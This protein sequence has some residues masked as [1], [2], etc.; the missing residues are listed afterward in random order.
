MSAVTEVSPYE[1][2]ATD[3]DSR[4]VEYVAETRAAVARSRTYRI[5]GWHH[6]AALALNTAWHY[7]R[8]AVSARETA[9]LYRAI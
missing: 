2:L 1:L 3:F 5:A 6:V 8:A 4:A 9:A 7:R